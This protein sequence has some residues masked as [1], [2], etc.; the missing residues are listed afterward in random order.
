LPRDLADVLHYFLPDSVPDPLV[1]APP[2]RPR[3]LETDREDKPSSAS[4][5]LP[6]LPILGIPIGDREIVPAALLW[7]LAVETAR[8][9][10]AAIVLAPASDRGS[11]LWPEPGDGPLG[12]ELHVCD[13]RSLAELHRSAVE[14]AQRRAQATR[15][16]GGLVFVRIPIQ[17][18]EAASTA[19]GCHRP[20]DGTMTTRA[21]DAGDEEQNEPEA[22][23]FI[24]LLLLSSSRPRDLR[25]AQELAET[26]LESSPNLEL[27]VTIH[28]VRSLDEARQAFDQLNERIEEDL[29]RSL[30]SYGLL[31]DDLDVYR[32]IAAQKPIGL[33]HP[34][35]RATRALMD[36]ARLLYEDARSRVLG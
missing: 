7:N 36:V 5:S 14:L 16:R 3:G 27:G 8:L 22:Q 31:V 6:H 21:H 9:G 23:P 17:W 33:A 11:P 29:G 13:A 25:E 1:E 12:A 28:G 4:P 18:L 32:A 15:R 26:L 34:Q 2:E 30:F 35:A 24:W 19:E 20:L 10:G